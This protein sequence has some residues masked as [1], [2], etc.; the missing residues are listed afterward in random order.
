MVLAIG[1]HYL[2]DELPP[3][4]AIRLA[5]FQPLPPGSF[6]YYCP[7]W[8][9]SSFNF[10]GDNFLVPLL[11]P[12][13]NTLGWV[14][15]LILLV[16]GTVFLSA[17]YARKDTTSSTGGLFKLGVTRMTWYLRDGFAFVPLQLATEVSYCKPES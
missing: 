7:F 2:G 9:L 11:V 15:L 6:L 3:V 8:R 10:S 1:V 17:L 4:E 16:L 14:R 12:F 5:W 13:G